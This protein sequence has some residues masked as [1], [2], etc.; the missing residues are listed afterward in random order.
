MS[1]DAT[2]PFGTAD[3]LGKI[4]TTPG[5]EDL[6]RESLKTQGALTVLREAEARK[7]I[8]EADEIENVAAFSRAS[9]FRHRTLDFV[10]PIVEETVEKALETATRWHR[11]S[12][13][14]ITFRFTSPGGSPISG[15]VLYDALR[16]ISEEGTKVITVSLGQSASMAG[17]LLQAGDE[18]VVGPTSWFL[19][20]ELT[21]D[22]GAQRITENDDTRE[23]MMKLNNSLVNILAQRSTLTAA[24]IRRRTKKG[25]W[26]LNADDAIKY[27]FADRKGVGVIDSSRTS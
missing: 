20:H 14:P 21:F 10:A 1:N 18:R 23:F 12:S 13:D 26:W 15:L 27:G 11:M 16:G 25:D 8:I 17:V 6:I 24:E 9:N 7:A 3:F 2:G 4:F 5:A 19:I 22:P